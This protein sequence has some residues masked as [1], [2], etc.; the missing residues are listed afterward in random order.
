M[1]TLTFARQLGG[2]L[3][4]AAFGWILLVA[5]GTRTGLTLV[6]VTAAACL[7]AA[8]LVSP[9]TEDDPAPAPHGT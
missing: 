4:T 8:L 9:R 5:P 3:G 2:S 6:L 7:L 1:G